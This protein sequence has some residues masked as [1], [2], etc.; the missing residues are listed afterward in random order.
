MLSSRIHGEAR[1]TATTHVAIAEESRAT[2]TPVSPPAVILSGGET[3]VT[4]RGDGTGDPNQEFATSAA[5]SVAANPETDAASDIAIAAVD[6]DG[7]DGATNAAGALVDSDTVADSE[8]ARA[9]LADN[10]VYSYL[11]S[12]DGLIL[13]GPT[14]TNLN[15]LRVL[16]VA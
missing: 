9:A 3:T 8:R 12:R 2:G 10:D 6:S 4:V 7:I 14:G 11:K 13:T 1:E 5:L 16:V 15:N